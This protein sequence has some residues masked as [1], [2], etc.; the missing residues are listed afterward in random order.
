MT[1][2]N[3]SNSSAIASS[4]PYPPLLTNGWSIFSVRQLLQF[5][6]VFAHSL[7]L[8]LSLCLSSPSR[9][10]YLYHYNRY[11]TRTR[12]DSYGGLPCVDGRLAE[13]TAVH[14]CLRRFVLQ[15]PFPSHFLV[16]FCRDLSATGKPLVPST[17]RKY[18]NTVLAA[19]LSS[20]QTNKHAK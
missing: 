5:F 13:T 11:S 9:V 18:T 14:A 6:I 8:S 12:S 2:R 3:S 16:P 15:S 19:Q 4:L 1:G 20:E 17:G 10:H 7:S